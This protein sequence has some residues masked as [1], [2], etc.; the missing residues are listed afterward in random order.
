MEDSVYARS[1]RANVAPVADERFEML[2]KFIVGD[3]HAILAVGVKT[4]A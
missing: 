4:R 2:V 3:N 1:G